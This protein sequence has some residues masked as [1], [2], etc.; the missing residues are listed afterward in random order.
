MARVTP[1]Q[2]QEKQ[3]RRLKG[4]TQDIVNGV[5]NVTEAPT[6]KAAAKADKW[7]NAV[8]NS[9]D[10]WKRGLSKVTL[11]EWKSSMIDKG[12]ARIAQGIDAAAPKVVAFA[13]KLLPYVD[14]GRKKIQ[15][16]PDISL[17]DSKQR[18]VAWIDHMAKFQK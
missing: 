1:Q 18:A 13:E 8:T 2:F 12:V 3:A 7:V 5:Q 15:S 16:M 14:E 10:K 11:D 6:Q 9:V 17:E 4:A